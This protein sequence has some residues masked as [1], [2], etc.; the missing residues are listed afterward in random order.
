[1]H[2]GLLRVAPLIVFG[3]GQRQVRIEH[4]VQHVDERHLGDGRAEQLRALVEH[5]SDQQPAGAAAADGETLGTAVALGEQVLGAGDEVVEAVL[6]VFQLAGPV[7]GFAQ[8]AAATDMGDGK[9]EAAFEQA[10]AGVGEPGIE[11][12]P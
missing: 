10:Q 12:C 2:L 6:L 7:P 1:M 5:R 8:F 4:A 9:D 3:D 11:L